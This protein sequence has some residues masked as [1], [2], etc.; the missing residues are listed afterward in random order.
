[1]LVL[2]ALSLACRLAVPPLQT[3]PMLPMS[4]S[5]HSEEV[6]I[7]T[8]VGA[9]HGTLLLPG[10][11]THEPVVLLIAG[12]GPTDR[13]G[14][15]PLL[16]GP[17]HGPASLKLLAEALANNGIASLRYDKRGVGASKISEADMR[18]PSF[19]GFVS[20]AAAWIAKLR[21]DPRFSRVV[22]AG[23]SEGSLL[24]ALAVQRF[25]GTRLIS[26]D[27]AGRPAAQILRE[28][29]ANA[30]APIPA[31]ADSIIAELSAG[32]TVASVPGPLMSVFYPAV[33]PYEISWFKYD[34]A[35]EIAK[36]SAPVLIIQ[37]NND[38]QIPV[39]DGH[40]LA[41]AAGP[42]GRLVVVDSMTHVLK[43]AGSDQQSQMR[44]YT[45][46]DIPL[47]PQ[48]VSAVVDFI[49]T[50]AAVPANPDHR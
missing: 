6:S 36:L 12:S 17:G 22:V 46:P 48:L 27:G 34:P 21:T 42:H 32:R 8:S 40:R 1:M 31:E 49:R 26:L 38:V 28:Q 18:S 25:A 41:A 44:T 2:A 24:G 37:G 10:A 19:E 4:D 35:A 30:P 16:G 43:L 15:N 5:A 47:A 29:L 50:Q 3:P 20:D 39:A 7:A 14:N 13:D 9:V 45:D 33:Q 23:H 11:A